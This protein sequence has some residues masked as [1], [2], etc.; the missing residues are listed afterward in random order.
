MDS[1]KTFSTRVFLAKTNVPSVFLHTLIRIW[2]ITSFFCFAICIFFIYDIWCEKIAKKSFLCRIHWKSIR[3]IDNCLK[4]L[5]IFVFSL[6]C[7]LLSRTKHGIFN[8]LEKI[9]LRFW[10]FP[11]FIKD[12]PN[13]LQKHNF[14]NDLF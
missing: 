5:E 2:D 13:V 14:K 10:D 6:V 12:V 4:K 3:R 7:K 9:N 8:E 11:F 1:Y